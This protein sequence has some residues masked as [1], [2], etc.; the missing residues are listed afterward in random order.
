MARQGEHGISWTDETWNP[1]R[2]CSR[3]SEGCRHCYAE[4]TAARFSGDID[5]GAGRSMADINKKPMPYD[6]L[7]IMRNDGPH[8]TGEVRFI[9]EHLADPLKW[10]KPKRIF[11]NSMSDLFHEKVQDEWLNKMFS[12]VMEIA[13]RH[14]FQILTKRPERMLKYLSWRWGDG[15]IPMRNIWL[16]VS[17]EDQ[18]TADERIPLLLQTPA[19]VRFISYEPALGPVDF[20]GID[21]GG[22]YKVNSLFKGTPFGSSER[23]DWLVVG[24]E[25]GPSA[26]SFNLQWARNVIAQCKAAG[27][28]CFV[29]QLGSNPQE[30]AYPDDV[31]DKEAARW[32]SD[33]WTRIWNAEGNHWRKY[34]RLKD[35]KGGDW[36]EWSPDLRVREYP[37]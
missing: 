31:T 34:Y 4:R 37:K 30:I 27:V 28:A 23:I 14:T 32:Q 19:A 35:R 3:V 1:I 10:R 26:R 29:K 21:F 36:S 25:S 22:G 5:L 12:D 11:V 6:G 16:G 7:A 9:E 13:T 8:W 18:A 15:R 24:G 20:N 33:G 17:V 2:G